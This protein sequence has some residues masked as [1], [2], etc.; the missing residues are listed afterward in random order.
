MRKREDEGDDLLARECEEREKKSFMKE[1]HR[2]V[3]CEC[4]VARSQLA[5]RLWA[6]IVLREYS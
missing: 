2:G 5:E 1:F 4:T 6:Y 3:S